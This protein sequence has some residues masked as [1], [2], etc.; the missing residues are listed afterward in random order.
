MMSDEAPP[1]RVGVGAL[2][3][4]ADGRVLLVKRR[5]DP[6]ADHW[7]LPGG[8]LDYGELLTV[9]CAREVAEEVGVQV[10]VGELVCIVDQIGV[11][12][13]GHWVA[14]VYRAR[15]VSGEPINREPQALTEVAWFSPDALPQPL[16]LSAR[17]ALGL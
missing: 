14:P 8:K 3:Q 2:I 7:G 4:D 9:C 13:G 12:G 11:P 6:E 17:R 1:P 5:R 15:V 16:T 10:E